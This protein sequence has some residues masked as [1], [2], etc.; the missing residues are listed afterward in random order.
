MDTDLAALDARLVKAR[1]LKQGMMQVLLTGVIRL[2]LDK[3]G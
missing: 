3:A 2:P 1:Q